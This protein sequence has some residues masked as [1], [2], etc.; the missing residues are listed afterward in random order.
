M[1][2]GSDLSQRIAQVE[3]AIARGR[4]WSLEHLRIC[5]MVLGVG[6]GLLAVAGFVLSGAGAGVGALVGGTIVG[7][8]FTV[9]A[10]AIAR[11]GRIN[12]RLTLPTALGT[13]FVKIVA[14][15]VVLTVVPQDGFLD[16]HWLAAAVVVGLVCWL[17]AHLRY[18]WTVKIFYVD[19]S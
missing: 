13:Y 6:T 10:V 4:A 9:S 7:A 17:G 5:W 19:P 11:A 15:G 8:F 14:L 16:R 12:P 18:V 2:R 3:K 1:T